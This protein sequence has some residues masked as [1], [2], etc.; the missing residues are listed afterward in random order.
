MLACDLM[1]FCTL[2]LLHIFHDWAAMN[3]DLS[4][5]TLIYVTVEFS[6]AFRSYMIWNDYLLIRRTSRRTEVVWNECIT[7]A[8]FRTDWTRRNPNTISTD[9][10]KPLSFSYAFLLSISWTNWMLTAVEES[11]NKC[12]KWVCNELDCSLGDIIIFGSCTFLPV[13]NEEV[14]QRTKWRRNNFAH[15]IL[16]RIR[17][18]KYGK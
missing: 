5:H 16:Q 13:G 7:P 18:W 1:R 17:L 12:H 4:L 15:T 8:E 11:G 3:V 14:K 9:G 2:F 6:E 10:G